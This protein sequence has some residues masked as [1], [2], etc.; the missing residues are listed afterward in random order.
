[1]APLNSRI[2]LNGLDGVALT[3]TT[4]QY[5]QGIQ[6]FSK[7]YTKYEESLQGAINI[8]C[9]NN[10]VEFYSAVSLARVNRKDVAK[11]VDSMYQLG[12]KYR[13]QLDSFL[14]SLPAAGSQ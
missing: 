7:S 9:R 1:M 13:T 12:T 11:D 2:A 3:Q 10:P 5:N 6:D 14:K 4:V 8:D